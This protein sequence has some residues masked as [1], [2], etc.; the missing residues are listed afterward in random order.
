MPATSENHDEIL[1]NFRE[2]LFEED[3]LHDGDSIG[4]D[5]ETLLRFLRAR[6]FD[7]VQSKKMFEECQEWR[8]TVEGVGMD[9]LYRQMDWLDYPEREAVLECWPM[10]F[11]QTD[12]TGR[13]VS[14]QILGQLDLPKLYKKCTPERHR[15]SIIVAGEMAMREIFP[16]AS[17]VAGRHIGASLVIVDLKGF[18]LSR[19]WQIRSLVGTW[20]KIMQD[21]HPETLGQVV[22]IN[23]P[24]T[25]TFIWNAIKHLLAAETIE[26]VNILGAD[27]KNELLKLVDEEKLPELV[28]G[29]CK[30]EGEGGCMFNN[31]GPWKEGRV[32]WG[33]NS[34]E[35]LPEKV[36]A[37]TSETPASVVSATA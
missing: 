35:S 4:T 25:F 10:F 12:K 37:E 36:S 34:K 23:A 5:D 19:F 8:K 18:G 27:Y 28:G 26:K 15:T 16:A 14:V 11:H 22:V 7:L 1:K 21:Y 2:Q 6:K 3:T 30:C 20:I 9:E 17:R 13:P 29:K 24:S 31:P 32:G 33:P